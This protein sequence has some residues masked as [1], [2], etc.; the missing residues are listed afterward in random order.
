[1]NNVIKIHRGANQ[2]WTE[3][4][5]RKLFVDILCEHSHDVSVEDAENSFVDYMMEEEMLDLK[6]I[7]DSIKG[8][9]DG[10]K[11]SKAI[12]VSKLSERRRSKAIAFGV[13]VAA[14]IIDS[15]IQ[16]PNDFPKGPR[17]VVASIARS[18]LFTNH[19]YKTAVTKEEETL[20]SEAAEKEVDRYEA[21]A[22]VWKA[23]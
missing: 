6:V 15:Y 22:K 7:Q 21:F 14:G 23:R 1:M 8:A 12:W 20:A 9:T 5:I 16:N 4:R 17:C 13:A 10:F 19:T 2:A 18:Q 11:E 3:R